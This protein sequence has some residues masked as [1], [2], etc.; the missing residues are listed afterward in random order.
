MLEQQVEVVK[1]QSGEG[2]KV[3]GNQ[4]NNVEWEPHHV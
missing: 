3:V 1:V 4:M 2:N